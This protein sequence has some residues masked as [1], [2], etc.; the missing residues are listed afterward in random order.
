MAPSN[1]F[2][3]LRPHHRR[4]TSQPT[5]P[6]PPL[7]ANSV[8]SP[9][10]HYQ[11]IPPPPPR[12]HDNASNHSSSP[13]SPFPPILPPIP[14]IASRSKQHP[15]SAKEHAG[16][17]SQGGTP[18]PDGH[19]QAQPSPDSGASADSRRDARRRQSSSAISAPTG[20][21]VK[22]QRPNYSSHSAEQ[23]STFAAAESA[24]T[25]MPTNSPFMSQSSL[26]S[27]LSAA[28][29][30][31]SGK[32]STS[33]QHSRSKKS[34]NLRNPMSLL[35]RRR[36]GQA[37]PNLS[38]ESL[39]SHKSQVVP[40]MALADDFDPSIRGNIVHDFSAPKSRR[41]H[42]YDAH[43]RDS[44]RLDAEVKQQTDDESPS[45]RDRSHT[46][47]FKEEFDT[48]ESEDKKRESAVRAETLA[49]Q[50]FLARNAF[51]E[52]P[53]HPPPPPPPFA[54]RRSLPP[55]LQLDSDAAG[56]APVPEASPSPTTG[57]PNGSNAIK[58]P[59]QSRSRATSGSMDPSFQPAGL[60]THLT[61]R[62]SRFSFQIAGV[63]S[64][65]QEE[66]LE[67]RH[68]QR[69]AAKAREKADSKLAGD[70]ED[71]DEEEE[72]MYD[73]DNMD[74]GGYEEEIPMLGDDYGDGF[75]GFSSDTGLAD[76][77]PA[78]DFSSFNRVPYTN[79]LSPIAASD[80]LGTPAD[81]QGNALSNAM[82]QG[83]AQ[84]Q[85]RSP[86]GAH[87]VTA[88]E[89]SET[90]VHGLGLMDI[91]PG[92]A[93][94]DIGAGHLTPEVS[95]AFP[96]ESGSKGPVLEDDDFYF[97]D[98]LLDEP[99][100]E[101][102]EHT[103]DESAFDDPNS[104]LYERPAPV[105]KSLSEDA[106]AAKDPEENPD[107]QEEQEP[108]KHALAPHPSMKQLSRNF[109][110][111]DP[112]DFKSPADYFSA[113][114]EAATKAEAEGR[115]VRKNSV[116]TT[117]DVSIYS[118][119]EE[120]EQSR[121]ATA[122]VRES[123]ESAPSLVQDSSRVSG[124]TENFLASTYPDTEYESFDQDFG[125]DPYGDSYGDDY[126]DYDS[127]LEDDPMIAAANAE[128]LAN[129][130]DGEYGSEFGF[131]A[132]AYNNGAEVT[133]GGYFGPSGLGRSVS[134][135]NAVR[136]PNLTPITERSE[137]STRNSFIGLGH[138]TGPGSA[139]PALPSPGLAQLARMSP[140]G[141]PPG[142]DEF[143]DYD[144]SLEQLMKLRKGAFGAGAGPTSSPG[145]GSAASSPRN[146][147]PLSYF[148]NSFQHRATSPVATRGKSA[149]D[150]MQGIEEQQ[151]DSDEGEDGFR[152]QAQ[153][154]QDEDEDEA[155]VNEAN[156]GDESEHESTYSV[157]REDNSS[158][159]N[160]SSH[161]L[162]DET[163][164]HGSPS[165]SPPSPQ[166]PGVPHQIQTRNL[167][168]HINTAA[169]AAYDPYAYPFLPENPGNIPVSVPASA[170]ST[171]STSSL[172]FGHSASAS[173]ASAGLAP[174]SQNQ[175]Q[176]QQ[177]RPTSSDGAATT[178]LALPS[179]GAGSPL[180]PTLFSPLSPPEQTPGPASPLW[181]RAHS[182]AH[183][184]TSSGAAESVTYV[185]E[186]IG[187]KS[188]EG[189]A[190]GEERGDGSGGGKEG[191][192]G[193]GE[194]DGEG[195]GRGEAE[196]TDGYRWVM[197]RRRT[198][199]SGEMELVGREVVRG[200]RI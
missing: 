10:A 73:Y 136:E 6:E 34:F 2:S 104:G 3:Y 36:S 54:K 117:T 108:G 141:L 111:G 119:D 163:P 187:V 25:S 188:T 176:K 100:P 132:N 27:V 157:Q 155:L 149:W 86:L 26:P 24:S 190:V 52:Q 60:P 175:Q 143:A 8:N 81:V 1:V 178:P 173:T 94:G 172:P 114:A 48:T 63:N 137:Y 23:P 4:T 11:D 151:S 147:S 42:S 28:E 138:F 191:D 74:G 101:E 107:L 179:P 183:S 70:D 116:A 140:Y 142:E 109:Q 195:H 46:P 186:R 199:N 65:E 7:S 121:P 161:D 84:A 113:L 5:T 181:D 69:A 135:R 98:G 87:P 162:N 83:L 182:S 171:T 93:E 31:A 59:P 53:D 153:G 44:S 79:P 122:A 96:Q 154:I 89:E 105:P 123:T 131:Y 200:G 91:G 64:S 124:A 30:S 15:T 134:G 85:Q 21:R 193:K 159:A 80:T 49:N 41:T 35:L 174:P 33:G 16:N 82:M 102:G 66:L 184:R 126:G 177:Q 169:A 166:R 110:S 99:S 164:H 58:T 32:G 43:I 50:D 133:N 196:G 29:K 145:G 40:A 168:Q 55:P 198:S 20:L 22:G 180:T 158:Q 68:K 13:V 160:R 125:G 165:A 77:L 130:F 139:N 62:A 97:D 197:E 76:S 17:T 118:Q 152:G 47:V 120:A 37:I 71:G 18:G 78:Y 127:A 56:L 88:D 189:G 19:L 90:N 51:P 38:D 12:L 128:A 75:G 167:P 39:V 72:D 156:R 61:S 9:V 103:F 95:P 112:F 170:I 146:S 148:P 129:D 14:R 57:S 45:K 185:R 144:M 115:F 150:A 194:R 106:E 192:K 92:A 67:E